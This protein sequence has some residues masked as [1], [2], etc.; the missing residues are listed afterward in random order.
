MKNTSSEANQI[1]CFCDT[2]M[3]PYAS[4]VYIRNLNAP[5]KV[6]LITA[7]TRIV[8]LNKPVILSR[9]ELIKDT[10][11]TGQWNL[12]QIID[13]HPVDEEVL[14]I[15]SKDQFTRFLP[16]LSFESSFPLPPKE[17]SLLK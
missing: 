13:I 11:S 7:K 16:C 17:C 12:V 2:S 15:S 9:L 6:N 8:P 4:V 14:M 1:C 3:K 10:T 5:I